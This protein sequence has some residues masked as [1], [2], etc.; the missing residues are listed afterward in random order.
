MTEFCRLLGR[1][2][3]RRSW[4]PVPE[5]AL[6]AALGEL[7]SIMTTGQKVTPKKALGAGYRFQYP[8]LEG[9]LKRIFSKEAHP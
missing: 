7:G 4:L 6:K 9:A 5:L 8:F 1:V 3:R 2:L